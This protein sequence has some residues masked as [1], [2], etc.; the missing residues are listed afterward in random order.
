MQTLQTFG[1]ADLTELACELSTGDYSFYLIPAVQMRFLS[2]QQFQFLKNAINDKSQNCQK[3]AENNIPLQFM[4]KKILA[5]IVIVR[6]IVIF[7]RKI[8]FY[9]NVLHK[10]HKK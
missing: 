1:Y 4:Q 2:F 3:I 10:K 6:K 8:A 5:I 9:R 7:P